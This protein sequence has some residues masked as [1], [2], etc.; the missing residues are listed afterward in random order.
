MKAMS[1]E[2]KAFRNLVDQVEAFLTD[3]NKN[4]DPVPYYAATEQDVA[5]LR[6]AV[7]VARNELEV[8]EFKENQND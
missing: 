6:Y 8:V 3:L 1:E 5:D 2:T 4:F 7:N